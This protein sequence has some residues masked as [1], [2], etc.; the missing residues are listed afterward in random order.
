MYFSIYGWIYETL[1]SDF[2]MMSVWASAVLPLVKIKPLNHVL[3]LGF[4]MR[5]VSDAGNEQDLFH[6]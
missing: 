1:Y 6:D 4:L 5:Y 2:F 3:T